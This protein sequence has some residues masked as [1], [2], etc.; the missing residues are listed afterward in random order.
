MPTI[1]SPQH[2]Y[3]DGELDTATSAQKLRVPKVSYSKFLSTAQERF[4]FDT[5][6]DYASHVKLTEGRKHFPFS[7][8][9]APKVTSILPGKLDLQPNLPPYLEGLELS[10]TRPSAGQVCR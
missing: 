10:A 7:L 9:R 5:E 4:S 2:P 8:K 6:E 3:Y 1:N